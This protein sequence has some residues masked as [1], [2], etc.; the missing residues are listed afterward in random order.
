MRNSE[1][2]AFIHMS[3]IHFR[4]HSG[5]P[6]DIDKPLRKAMLNDLK[7]HALKYVKNVNGI[8]VCGDLAYSG[9]EEEF[10]IANKFLKEVA[11]VSGC[12]LE[13]VFCVAG[14]HDVDQSVIKGSY[15]IETMQ[16]ELNRVDCESADNSDNLDNVLRKIQQDPYIEGLL[17]QSI[18]NYNK[19][20]DSLLCSYTVKKQNWER[21]IKLDDKYTLK[22]WGMN[23]VFISNHKDH[24]DDNGNWLL[25]DEE[26]KMVMNCS[27]IPIPE[28]NVIYMTLCHHPVQCWNNK[29][30]SEMMDGRVKLQLYGHK[31][32]Q[33]IDSDSRRIRINTGA[34]QPERG[35]DWIPLYNWITLLVRENRLIVRIYPRIYDDVKGIFCKDEKNCDTDREYKE[36]ELLLDDF[37]DNHDITEKCDVRKITAMSKEIAYRYCTL[38]E[39]DLE[40]IA[41]EFKQIDFRVK[42][43]DDLLQQLQQMKIENEFLSALKNLE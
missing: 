42:Q 23:S 1:W 27:Q 6:Y 7:N 20:A 32:I 8:L 15:I 43:I 40:N 2:L 28:N 19:F 29:R 25:D 34:L 18:G 38:C 10:Q 11:E 39:S 14:N 33:S 12:S 36:V 5:D 37:A 35:N 17:Y 16:K 30:L 21:K 22:L 9:K 24:Q 3:D 26:R 41:Q 13:N 4:S 31:H